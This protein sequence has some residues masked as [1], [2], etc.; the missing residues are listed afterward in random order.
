ME[1][2]FSYIRDRRKE[3]KLTLEDVAKAV[4]VSKGT[5]S[6]WEKGNIKNMRSDKIGL[7]TQVLQMDINEFFKACYNEPEQKEQEAETPFVFKDES[8][9]D[10]PGYR[11]SNNVFTESDSEDKLVVMYQDE[12][13]YAHYEEFHK[14][15]YEFIVNTIKMLK[16]KENSK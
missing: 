14:E 8:I 11:A 13:G 6:K 9:D 3:L 1:K 4:G 16:S 15:D 5:V 12:D 10:I 2:K 7:L